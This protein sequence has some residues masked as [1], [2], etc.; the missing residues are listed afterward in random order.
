MKHDVPCTKI[1]YDESHM[2]KHFHETLIKGAWAHLR[3]GGVSLGA[4]SD[5]QFLLH[6]ASASPVSTSR[7]ERH[8]AGEGAPKLSHDDDP[9]HRSRRSSRADTG[10]RSE[11]AR[12][13]TIPIGKSGAPSGNVE[14]SDESF[15]CAQSL[16]ADP[17]TATARC[18]VRDGANDAS[19]RVVDEECSGLSIEDDARRLDDEQ[20][21]SV[22]ISSALRRIDADIVD[23]ALKALDEIIQEIDAAR[24]LR[25]QRRHDQDSK[26]EPT[27]PRAADP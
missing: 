16:A 27:P 22:S 7:R 21:P 24:L 8:S 12:E 20:P 5:G 25:Q 3:T 19:E 9:S 1:S 26:T 4:L 13:T 2:F 18:G 11:A 10:E 15:A 17:T 14:R 6:A 23:P